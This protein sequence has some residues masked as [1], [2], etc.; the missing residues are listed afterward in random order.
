MKLSNLNQLVNIAFQYVIQTSKKYQ[1]DESHSLKH[2]MDVLHFSNQIYQSELISNPSLKNHKEIIFASSIL[3]DMC[4]KKY[5]E[6]SQGILEMRN[7]LEQQTA[8]KH[9]EI[10]VIS[11]IISTMSY[12]TVKKNGYPDL[13]EY[14]LAYHIVR[15]A[16]LL[17]AYELERCIIYKMMKQHHS[18]TDA[19]DL[20]LTLFQ[21]RILLYLSDQLFITDFSKT[22]AL[23]LHAKAI[24]DIEFIH[25]LF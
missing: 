5:M 20:S 14:Q 12:S 16:D 6:E 7:Y 8:L 2:S 9:Q 24:K 21:E 1:I 4:D 13:G 18:Y 25:L 23:E 15:E 17:A 10:E 3:H 19:V 22:K 11:T